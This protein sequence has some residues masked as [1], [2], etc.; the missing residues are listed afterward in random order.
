MKRIVK[1]SVSI[2]RVFAYI[3][4]FAI[5]LSHN[6]NAQGTTDPFPHQEPIQ[7]ENYLYLP[8]FIGHGMGID[9]YNNNHENTSVTGYNQQFDSIIAPPMEALSQQFMIDSTITIYGI[10]IFRHMSDDGSQ[11]AD[12]LEAWT[13]EDSL[14]IRSLDH[15]TIYR[16][17]CIAHSSK[18]K[19]LNGVFEYYFD[20]LTIST[21]FTVVKTFSRDYYRKHAFYPYNIY[22]TYSSPF[23]DKEECHSFQRPSFK[24]Y[25]DSLWYDMRDVP[26][27][28]PNFY[29]FFNDLW[30]DSLYTDLFILPI[31]KKVPEPKQT[32][33]V[34]VGPEHYCGNV[35]GGGVY[36][37]LTYVTLQATA[38]DNYRFVQ[39]HDGNTENPRT[40]RVMSDST[41]TAI[42]DTVFKVN[43]YTE[44]AYYGNVL[45]GGSY[46][47]GSEATLRVGTRANYYFKRWND[48]NCD[49]PRIITVTSD[50]TLV[51]IL[52]TIPPTSI[53]MAE[54]NEDITIHPNPATTIL[55]IE[56]PQSCTAELRNIKGVL[57][58]TKQ[59]QGNAQWNIE[60]LPPGVYML[61]FRN[62]DWV[63][64]RKFVKK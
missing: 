2:R 34:A 33:R 13:F 35:E 28:H 54:I 37:R 32:I 62:N 60:V 25:G 31:Y 49:N 42:F 43:A 27:P 61:T 20:S 30:T 23:Y 10:A 29:T 19:F 6:V 36:D 51:A 45:G 12:S 9:A 5:L 44:P 22:A 55:N 4:I 46:E 24:H 40:I 39:W 11:S 63:I 52:D 21:P 26:Y 38:N 16:S 7:P 18:P 17:V 14:Q 41:F 3:I 50:T 1:I 15:D 58:E 47:M 57:I 53:D 59:L 48:G 56:L 8:S 64:T